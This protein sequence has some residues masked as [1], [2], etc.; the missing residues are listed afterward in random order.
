MMGI[1]CDFPTLIFGDNK[2][3]LTN[4]SVPD[5]VLRQRSLHITY[6]FVREGCAK[7]EWRLAYV[8][9]ADN[10]ADVCTK[11]IFNNQKRMHL[12]SER[13]II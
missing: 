4:S 2:S 7:D 6:T 8:K 3:E 12:L 11:P 1:P 10:V 13:C 9:S 5:S